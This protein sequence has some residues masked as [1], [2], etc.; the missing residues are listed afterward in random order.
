M[1]RF[2]FAM[3][4]SV[5]LDDPHVPRAVGGPTS[6]VDGHEVRDAQDAVGAIEVL[7][8]TTARTGLA[9]AV[10]HRQALGAL[11]VNV[12]QLSDPDPA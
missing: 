9:E 8:Q 6:T 1:P 10:G 3:A 12:V 7:L 4:G 11:S 2:A 5:H